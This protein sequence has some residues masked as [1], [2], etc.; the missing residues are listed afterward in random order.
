[1]TNSRQKLKSLRALQYL[2]PVFEF[3]KQQKKQQGIDT[4]DWRY[5]D[6]LKENLT[7][8]LVKGTSVLELAYKDTDKDL[9]LPTDTENF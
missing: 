7:I 9:V 2:K 5:A 6:W 4:Q 8:E 3:V 1:M